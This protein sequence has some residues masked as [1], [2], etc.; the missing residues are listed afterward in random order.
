MKIGALP[1]ALAVASTVQIHA[2]Q[3]YT[4]QK[5][6]DHGVAIVRLTDAAAGVEVSIVPSI[7]NRA[8]EMKVHGKNILYFPSADVGEFQKQPELGGIPFLAPWANRLDEQD[9]WANGKKYTFNMTLGNVRGALPIHGMLATSPLWEVMEVAVD[10]QSAHVTSRLQFWKNPDLM[11]QWPFAHE[12]EMTYRLRGGVL[13]VRVT[14]TNLSSDPMPVVL[15]FHPYYRIPDVPRDEWLATLPARKIVVADDRLIP[16]GELKPLDL[17]N[18][19]P[20]KGH[21]LDTGFTDLDRDAEGRAHFSIESKGMKVET[22]FGPK[23]P[24]AIIW[25]PPPPAGQT[26]DFICFEP[27]TGIT[28]AVNLQHEGKYTGLQTLAPGAKWTESF[29]VRSSGI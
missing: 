7:G 4:A 12:Y 14:V 13:E 26:R 23:Y 2:A 6:S 29:W 5:T 25:E 19:L 17:P 10:R 22:L 15:G 1:F 11:A 18:P 3:N 16:T 24:V 9:F 21:N 20:L 8:Y 27:M 28:S